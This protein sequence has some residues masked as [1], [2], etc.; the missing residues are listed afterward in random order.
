MVGL[1]LEVLELLSD[2][3]VLVRQVQVLLLVLQ[4][5]FAVPGHQ[6][7]QP[8]LEPSELALL[9]LMCLWRACTGRVQRAGTC[10]WGDGHR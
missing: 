9:L 7:A 8:V 4:V 1:A 5:S 3:A 6:P 2:A 10:K